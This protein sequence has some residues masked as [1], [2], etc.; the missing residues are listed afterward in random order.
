MNLQK[1]ELIIQTAFKLRMA[2]QTNRILPP[3]PPPPK[4]S[5]TVVYE[6]TITG[7]HFSYSYYLVLQK[8]RKM[9]VHEF[10]IAI[11]LYFKSFLLSKL[12]YNTL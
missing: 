11:C 12:M 4:K 1:I 6:G 5:R 8:E 3:H 10:L 7:K 2:L 9:Q